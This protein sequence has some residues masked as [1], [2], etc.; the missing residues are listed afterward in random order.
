MATSNIVFVGSKVSPSVND[1][2]FVMLNVLYSIDN[3]INIMVSIP[4][5]TWADIEVL[6]DNMEVNL[7]GEYDPII[8]KAIRAANK[9]FPNWKV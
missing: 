2:G 6:F 5:N 3:Q 7:A 9:L 4:N 1:I 8:N